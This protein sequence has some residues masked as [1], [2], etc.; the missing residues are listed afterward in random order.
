MATSP[1]KSRSKF[2]TTHWSLILSVGQQ[3][4]AESKR[5]LASLCELYWYPLYVFLRRQGHDSTQAQDYTQG[6][7]AKLLEKEYL[8]KADP[9]RGRFRTFLLV[10]LK[11]FL[12]NERAKQ[13][14]QKR[15]GDYQ[16]LSF[17]FDEGEKHYHL[18]PADAW[19]PEKIYQRRWALT[20]LDSVVQKLEAEYVAK[21]KERLFEALKVFLTGKEHAPSYA[22]LEQHLNLSISALK[23]TVHRLRQRYKELLREQ[24]THTLSDPNDF[25][26]ELNSLMDA[27]RGG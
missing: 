26:D 1:V 18:E 19:T 6:F 25:E 15:G 12:A 10:M 21:G 16:I 22:E 20:V 9:E 11:R 23:V 2:E 7:V 13:S 5:A 4:S 24:I 17:N 14:T 27:L 3:D 8:L